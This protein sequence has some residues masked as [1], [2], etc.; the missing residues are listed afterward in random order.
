M[1]GGAVGDAPI[2]VDGPDRRPAVAIG[3]AGVGDVPDDVGLGGGG[4]GT[5]LV[6]T[7][8]V[9]VE[10]PACSYLPNASLTYY[11]HSVITGTALNPAFQVYIEYAAN[12]VTVTHVAGCIWG[13]GPFFV[14]FGSTLSVQLILSPPT[15]QLTFFYGFGFAARY[16]LPFAQFDH[17]GQNVFQRDAVSLGDIWPL[18]WNVDVERVGKKDFERGGGGAVAD[19]ETEIIVVI[20]AGGGSVGDTRLF[21]HAGGGSAGDTR[22][23]L[24]SGGGGVSDGGWE[25]EAEPEIVNTGMTLCGL[26][27][28][29]AAIG[30]FAWGGPNAI[31]DLGVGEAVGQVF[32]GIDSLDESHALIARDFGFAIPSGATIVGVVARYEGRYQGGAP[33]IT[34]CQL[35]HDA[36]FIGSDN[37]ATQS[38]AFLVQATNTLVEFG[39]DSDL[40]GAVL[41]PALINSSDFGVAF[42]VDAVDL[43][44]AKISRLRYV[45]ID[46]YYYE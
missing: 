8:Y 21:T 7:K 11:T 44:G 19:G 18:Q 45:W 1:G 33:N 39:G 16:T 36:T 5:A 31:S 35:W 10:T 3:G 2:L 43:A 20:T 34:L 46:V 38:G 40:W 32:G 29:N 28:N 37:K 41:T 14:P 4:V 24:H 17:A 6:D 13:F 15:A 25:E 27:E 22:L 26:G 30:E 42:A 12:G 9:I 23:Y